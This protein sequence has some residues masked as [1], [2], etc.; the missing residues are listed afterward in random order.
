M[1]CQ[2][3][4][5]MDCQAETELKFCWIEHF[6]EHKMAENSPWHR[7]EPGSLQNSP[8]HRV[9]SPLFVHIK[10]VKQAL[11]ADKAVKQGYLWQPASIADADVA[12]VAD[13]GGD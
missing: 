7:K 5:K 4:N 8:R 6:P 9:T 2:A 11:T 10:V 13:V 12:D 1:D 3:E